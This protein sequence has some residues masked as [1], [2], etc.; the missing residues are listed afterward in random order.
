MEVNTEAWLLGG[1]HRGTGS[2]EHAR[3]RTSAL[4]GIRFVI[5]LRGPL[6]ADFSMELLLAGFIFVTTRSM[7]HFDVTSLNLIHSLQRPQWPV[8][9]GALSA[10]PAR[11]CVNMR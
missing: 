7:I 6:L 8:S 9:R 3:S 10:P 1:E 5:A 4:S 11:W 2:V